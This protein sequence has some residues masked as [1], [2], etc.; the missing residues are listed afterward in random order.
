M[1]A[2]ISGAGGGALGQQG[3]KRLLQ[4]SSPSAPTA[5]TANDYTTSSCT[6]GF[7]SPNTRGSTSLDAV[8]E[9]AGTGAG[10][11]DACDACSVDNGPCNWLALHK[12]TGLVG[13]LGIPIMSGDQVLGLLVAADRD[14]R[15]V[16]HKG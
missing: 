6:A 12:E 11:G 3:T 9:E 8:Y 5:P 2:V 4:C 13:F 10:Q 15:V 7:A 14:A 1:K 16:K